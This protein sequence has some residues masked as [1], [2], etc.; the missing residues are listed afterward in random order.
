MKSSI[1]RVTIRDLAK[2]LGISDRAVSAALNPGET[3]V[4]LKLETA[5]RIR[6]LASERNYRPD[7]SA[8]SMRSGKFFNIGYFEARST[9][10]HYPLLGEEAGIC[11][12]ASERG[13]R[14]VLVK[15]PSDLS[16]GDNII[17]SVFGE[18]HLDALIVSH[19]GNLPQ[20]Y[21]EAING[22]MFPIIYVNE[23]RP[24]NAVYV[25]DVK[26]ARDLTVHLAAQG[27]RR[28]VF[29]SIGGSS[30]YSEVDRSRGYREAML[31]AG[32][33]PTFKG[34]TG[35]TDD[36]WKKAL[37][38]SLAECPDAEAFICFDDLTAHRI[39]KALYR[40]GKRVP[41]DIAIASFGDGASAMDLT[42]MRLPFYNMAR[43]A[44]E[45]SLELISSQAKAVPSQVL[46]AELII[47]ETARRS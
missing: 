40:M 39:L 46:E 28:I 36:F 44:V 26:A 27:Y 20:K 1:K 17:S 6:K 22:S 47:G 33:T 4:K 23:K 35:D 45:M 15:L 19:L 34:I 43:L 21:K 18:A 2:E 10:F 13:Y 8:R 16:L 7:T 31:A 25:D 3:K 42:S 37:P 29:F 9:R 14:V 38:Q 32:L 41:E 24:K 12:A 5:E 11:D 30:H